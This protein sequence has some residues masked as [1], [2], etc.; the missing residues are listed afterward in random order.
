MIEKDVFNKKSRPSKSINLAEIGDLQQMLRDKQTALSQINPKGYTNSSSANITYKN[1][2]KN[3]IE[4]ALDKRKNV[5][6][7]ISNCS[8]CKNRSPNN[9]NEISI[10]EILAR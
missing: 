2:I 1:I 6:M 9:S 10:A 8:M 7:D 4:V 3:E 5:K